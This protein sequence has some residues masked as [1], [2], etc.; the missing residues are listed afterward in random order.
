[1]GISIQGQISMWNRNQQ[2]RNLGGNGEKSLFPVSLIEILE[3][4]YWER[5]E[6][7]ETAL[8]L[9]CKTRLCWRRNS[10]ACHPPPLWEGHLLVQE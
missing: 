7:A 9:Q 8:G 6:I 10:L 1:M 3:N 5:S 4:Q 2:I